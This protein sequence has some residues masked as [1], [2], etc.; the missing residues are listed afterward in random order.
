[1]IRW[2]RAGDR[3]GL[4]GGDRGR[5]LPGGA[6]VEFHR[7]WRQQESVTATERKRERQK[8]KRR[9]RKKGG[10]ERKEGRK[11]DKHTERQTHTHRQTLTETETSTKTDTRQERGGLVETG[12]NTFI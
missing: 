5:T 3:T 11:G 4:E 9:R 1:M 2:W 12:K 6:P 10:K 8:K 7:R